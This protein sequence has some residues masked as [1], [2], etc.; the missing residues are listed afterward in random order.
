MPPGELSA[1]VEAQALK[2]WKLIADDLDGLIQSQAFDKSTFR[3][4]SVRV[5]ADNLVSFDL[6]APWVCRLSSK[7]QV[8]LAGAGVGAVFLDTPE[9]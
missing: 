2:L 7:V 4:L 8:G 3:D 9:G 6:E 1:E 5:R